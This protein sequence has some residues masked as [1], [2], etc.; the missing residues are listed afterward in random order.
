LQQPGNFF[1]SQLNNR[2]KNFSHANANQTEQSQHLSL[3]PYNRASVTEANNLEAS[4]IPLTG[5]RAGAGS[6]TGS[7]NSFLY[8][9]NVKDSIVL[10]TNEITPYQFTPS[11]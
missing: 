2:K 1:T 4:P 7:S 5:R 6:V 8:N 11:T 9:S 3:S 10:K